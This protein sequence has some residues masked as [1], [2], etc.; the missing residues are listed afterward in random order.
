LLEQ[1]FL[2]RNKNKCT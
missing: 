2:W 1:F